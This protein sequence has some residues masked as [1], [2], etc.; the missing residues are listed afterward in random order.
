MT[1][2][3]F[4]QIGHRDKSPEY[5][6]FTNS[7]ATKQPRHKTCKINNSFTNPKVHTRNMMFKGNLLA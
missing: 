3:P 6:P 2:N 5:N 4:R 7:P 1:E